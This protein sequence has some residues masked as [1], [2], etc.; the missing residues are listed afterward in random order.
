MEDSTMRDKLISNVLLAVVA[1]FL[2]CSSGDDVLLENQ[3]W[4]IASSATKQEGVFVYGDTDNEFDD[5]EA[6]RAIFIGGSGGTRYIKLWDNNDVAHVYKDGVEIGT[7]TPDR[8][9]DQHSTLTGALTGAVTANDVL[10]IYMPSPML[11]YTCQNG[12]MADLS[13]KDY[14]MTTAQILS[15]DGSKVT[16]EELMF[17]SLQGYECLKFRDSNNRLL[18]VKQLIITAASGKLVHKKNLLTGE[19]T[20]TDTLLINTVKEAS[21]VTNDPTDIWVCILN[22]NGTDS[23]TFTVVAE[24]GNVYTPQSAWNKNFSVGTFGY[25]RRSVACTTVDVDIQTGI[26]PPE[27]DTPDVQQLTL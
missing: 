23:Y 22:E 3:Q 14:M 1:A 25:G 2:G 18:H 13:K 20:Y 11:D 8:K 19:T 10:T 12:S 4:Q 24:D 6:T 21:T 16:T 26:T 15:M 27:S 9:G 17:K 7:M 5:D